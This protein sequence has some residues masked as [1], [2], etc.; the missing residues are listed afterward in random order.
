[1][2]IFTGLVRDLKPL[3]SANSKASHRGTHRLSLLT[4]GGQ[5]K[6]PLVNKNL[7]ASAQFMEREELLSPVA[8]T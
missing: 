6:F 7:R 3:T 5:K 2:V 1:M 4:W 8:F